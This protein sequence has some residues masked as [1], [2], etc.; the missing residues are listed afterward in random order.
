MFNCVH[1]C[2]LFLQLVN[3]DD[4][5]VD[6]FLTVSS[7]ELIPDST[8]Q[9]LETLQHNVTNA[10]NFTEY[11]QFLNESVITFDLQELANNLTTLADQFDMVMLV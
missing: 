4:V 2:L 1:F 3:L 11:Q 5:D 9:N 7:N 10:I 8:R 6:S